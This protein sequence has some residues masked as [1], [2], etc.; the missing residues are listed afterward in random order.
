[1]ANK[2]IP[3]D[4]VLTNP[5]AAIGY[6]RLP[7]PD[8]RIDRGVEAYGRHVVDFIGHDLPWGNL[9]QIAI[10]YFAL[11]DVCVYFVGGADGPI[12]IGA[13]KAPLERLA[14]FQIGSPV[15][16]KIHALAHGGYDLE[17]EY[18][19]R[20]A[21]HRLHGEWFEPHPDILA[22]IARLTPREPELEK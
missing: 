14:T 13:T 9:G 20:F 6:R 3:A 4:H 19:A 16:L 17:R 12:K 15:K 7:E 10:Q 1:M 8:F 22:E 21:G 11:P 18:H 5:V 2:A